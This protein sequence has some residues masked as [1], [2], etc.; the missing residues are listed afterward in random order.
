MTPASGFCYLGCK[1]SGGERGGRSRGHETSVLRRVSLVLAAMAL[2][3]LL[4][5]GMALA[6][7]KIGTDGPDNLMGIN[8]ADNL[9]GK[10]GNDDLFGMKGA[11][12]W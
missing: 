12:T 4:A 1:R 6:V 10:G 8:N 9:S 7:N 11:T 2:A 5:S 3:L